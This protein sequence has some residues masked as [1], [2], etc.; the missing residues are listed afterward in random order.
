KNKVPERQLMIPISM[1]YPAPALQP[2][3]DSNM[4]PP[5]TDAV[6]YGGYLLNAAACA[7][8]HTPMVKGQFDFSKRLAGGLRFDAGSFIVNSAN[9][10]PDSATGI[11]AWNEER[12]MNKFAVCREEKGYNYDA[13]KQNTYM[14]VTLY[15]GMTDSDLKAIYAYL[16][17]VPAVSNKVEKYPK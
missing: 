5:E 2:S 7:D 16:R 15:A 10:T 12:F 9:I 1:A 11:G 3:I 14:P 17:T 4:R 6:Q 13:G 8:C